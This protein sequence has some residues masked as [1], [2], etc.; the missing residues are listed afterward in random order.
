MIKCTAGIYINKL[1]LLMLSCLEDKSNVSF[2]VSAHTDLKLFCHGQGVIQM[3]DFMIHLLICF[4]IPSCCIFA[5][6]QKAS[7]FEMFCS[8]LAFRF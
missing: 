2:E 4:L 3:L 6:K 5:G 1:Q 7:L 8:I